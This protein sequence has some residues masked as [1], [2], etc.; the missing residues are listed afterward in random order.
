MGE[1]N[2]EKPLVSII[3]PV[4]NMGDMLENSVKS[5]AAQTYD[6]VEILLIDDGS[7]DDSLKVCERIAQR[8]SRVKVFHLSLIHI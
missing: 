8:D 7:K 2:L 1:I 4:Y 5:A 3:I 6:N